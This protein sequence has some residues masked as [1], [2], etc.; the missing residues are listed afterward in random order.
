MYSFGCST[1]KPNGC[2]L[3]PEGSRM[4]FFEECKNSS[5]PYLKIYTHL[6]YA[7]HLGEP[8]GYKSSEKLNIY[9]AWEKW[10]ELHQKGWTEVYYHYGWEFPVEKILKNEIFNL[11]AT[12]LLHICN[13][14]LENNLFSTY[15]FTFVN[16]SVTLINNYITSMANSNVTTESGG[17]Q[18]M[19]PTETR[20]YIDESVAYD[21]YPQNAEKVNGRW[22]MIGLVALVG[23]YVST[24]QIIPGIF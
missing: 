19:F 6:F 9:A 17:R 24:G 4:I 13:I 22:A 7:N 10:H 2:L 23:A 12:V 1:S 16:S 18:N 8:G 20:P 11:Y 15:Y 5:K 14:Y 3:N 21:S